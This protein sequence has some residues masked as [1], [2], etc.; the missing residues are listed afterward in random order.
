MVFLD[1]DIM[2]DLLRQYQPSVTWLDSLGE[3]EVVIPR[4]VVMELIQGCRSKEEQE[5]VEKALTDYGVAWPLPETCSKAA[6][7][8]SRC[9][10]AHG[11]GIIDALIGQMAV[12]L[13]VPL[14]TF[15]T[16]HY[17]PI[18]GLSTIQPYEKG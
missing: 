1:T 13:E 5:K 17:E 4:F 9:H 15:N 2:V 3:V 14:H 10:L 8:F 16:R 7:A 18:A 12:D 11:L 6:S